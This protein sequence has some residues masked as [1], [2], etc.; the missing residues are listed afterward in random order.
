[1]TAPATRSENWRNSPVEN[2]SDP[3]GFFAPPTSL[4]SAAAAMVYDAIGAAHTAAELDDL[5]KH[6]WCRWGAGEIDDTDAAYLQQYAHQRR[7]GHAFRQSRSIRQPEL[8]ARVPVGDP[9]LRPVGSRRPVHSRFPR[10][11]EQRSPDKQASFDRR[12]RL[13]YS[14]VLPRH[15]AP[16]L[17]IA[18]MAVMRVV[19]DEYVRAAA[20]ELSIAAIAARAG[21]CRKTAKRTIQKAQAERLVSV[22]ERPIRGQRHK[23]NLV[24]IISLE[25]LKWLRRPKD[26]NEAIQAGEGGDILY[27]PRI[28]KKKMMVM[29]VVPSSISEKPNLLRKRRSRRVADRPRKPSRS[30]MNSHTSPATRP[31]RRRNAGETLTRRG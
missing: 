8:F 12:H 9:N 22:D 19:A 11:C 31:P 24:R 7:P 18:D 20:C 29:R 1:M 14:G 3:E 17:T 16:R 13:A 4:A 27:P 10:R 6:V 21:V 2:P 15:L 23:P 30:R 28:Q 26:R 5:V 25:W